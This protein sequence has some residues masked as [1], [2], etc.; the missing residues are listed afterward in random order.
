MKTIATLASLATGVLLAFNAAA[1]DHAQHQTPPQ[2]DHSQH[3]PESA[4]K[5]A[6]KS[7]PAPMD[8]AAMGHE[9]MD[10]AAM[11][12]SMPR[13]QTDQPITPIPP[14]TDADRAA[15][16]P[17]A[18]MQMAHGEAR[19]FYVLFNRLEAFDADPGSGQA[20]EGQAWV[21]GDLNKVWLRSEGER[22]GGHTE[23]ADLE[24]LYGRAIAPW[25]DL[26][27]GVRHDFKPGAS[28]DFVAF[29]VQGMAPYKFEI[30]ATAYLGQ[31]GQIAARVEVEYETLLT[32][33]LILQPLVELDFHGKD[34][35]R[36]G[37]GS[38]LGTAEAGL[39][40]RYEI[41]RQFAP[42]IGIVH[43]RAY[44]NTATLR[45]AAGDAT[46]DTHVVAGLRLWF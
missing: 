17:P 36:R 38:G 29:G 26:V 45:R 24:V 3:Q 27:A 19:Q 6:D 12:H 10:H 40:L 32:N 44:G 8:H 4:E 22:V 31:S 15:A 42:Y 33:R 35:L 25:W 34:D 20:W 21:G 46:S 43:E 7:V 37:I 11:G 16:Q 2:Q 13:P 18:G 14:V 1:Q 5:P 41:T 9:A 28:Q 30:A 39:R 23:S